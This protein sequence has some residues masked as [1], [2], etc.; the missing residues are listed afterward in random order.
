M[1][2]PRTVKAVFIAVKLVKSIN[3]DIVVSF[4]G[5]ISVP[6]IFASWICR[7]PSI[8]HEQ[9]SV[10]SLSTKI[11]SLF[12]NKIALSFAVSDDN[13]KNV[14]TGN[15]IRRQVFN[16][17]SKK[18]AHLSAIVQK[19]PLIYITGGNQGSSFFNNLFPDIIK[20][21]TQKYTIIHQVGNLEY[22]RI[23]K[24][25]TNKRYIPIDYVNLGDIGWVL[26]HSSIIISRAG[27]NICQEIVALNKPSI[28]IPLPVS[29]QD[30]QL[31]NAKWV[32]S[33]IANHTIISPQK[34]TTPKLI[35]D[36]IT[37]LMNKSRL[38]A[39]LT[40]KTNHNL[41]TLIHEIV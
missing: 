37:L 6:V 22:Q 2:I 16:N 1:G 13:P 5:Y 7:K 15:L 24:T 40:T 32:Q 9:T 23:S 21:L 25:N 31:L 41:L 34:D 11:N 26:N 39:K 36:T 18:F 20:T 3:P 12:V 4:G 33:N 27:G 14:V 30:E 19:Y 17:A 38:M 28:L 29:Q 35:A 10:L 8:T